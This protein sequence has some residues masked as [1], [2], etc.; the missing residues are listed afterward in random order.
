MPTLTSST[1]REFLRLTGQ[2]LGLAA[3]AGFTP[4]LLSSPSFLSPNTT[5]EQILVVIHLA[6]GND[7]LNTLIPYADDHYY[8]LRPRI[9][10]PAA[11]AFKLDE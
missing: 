4:K 9:A 5:N 3:L 2:G 6:G 8:R 1:R 7:G 11:K 10:I